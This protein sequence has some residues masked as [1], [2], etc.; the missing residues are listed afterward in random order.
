MDGAKAIDAGAQRLS[1][2]FAAWWLIGWALASA[3]L[4]ARFGAEALRLDFSEPDNTMRLVQVRDL[5]GGQGWFD[6]VQHRLNPPEGVPSHWARWIDAAIAAPIALL[7]PLVGSQTAQ[8]VTAFV[9]PLG[10]LAVFMLLVARLS[11]ELAGEHHAREAE[12]AGPIIA[13][14]ALPAMEKF[15]PGSFDHHNVELIFAFAAMLG[16][17]RMGRSPPMGALAGLGLGAALA[18]AAEGL[19]QVVAGVVAGGLMWLFGPATYRRGLAWFGAGLAASSLGFFLMLVPPERW[20]LRV[21]DSMSPA[22][23]MIGLLSGGAAV[24]LGAGRW[25]QQVSLVRR[26]AIA[27]VVGGVAVVALVLTCPELLGGGYAAL[28][29]EMRQLWMPQISEARSLAQVWADSPGFALGIA[30]SAAAGVATAAVYLRTRWREPNGW[31]V[32]A[33]LGAGWAVFLWQ[34]RGAELATAFA[35]PFGAWACVQARA[36]WKTATGPR[37]L[38]VFAA[39]C[40]ISVSAA[41]QAAGA[42]VQ[43][44]AASAETLASYDSRSDAADACL[45]REAIAPLAAARAGVIVNPFVTGPAILEWTKHSVVAA[46]YHRDGE[47][48]TMMMDAMRA[49]PEAARGPLTSSNADYLLV[50]PALPETQWYARHPL[51]P[52]GDPAATL[53]ARLARNEAPDWLQPIDLGDTPLRL[54]RILR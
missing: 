42:Q 10:L 21:T 15:A 11:R 45:S 36:A 35:I 54:Y 8:L 49:T 27:A 46:P 17:M 37:G 33:F 20:A 34:I 23:L 29:A 53:S 50:C 30:G 22:F 44:R 24:L 2:P 40:A 26:A 39:V 19:P 38:G 48:I 9:W 5:L 4:V 28:G 52:G 51:T 1:R 31:I 7:T 14:L 25:S 41:W 6:N 16:L 18:T 3:L 12:I 47:G 32:L 13:A 43:A